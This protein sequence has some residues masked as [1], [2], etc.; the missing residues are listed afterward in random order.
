VKSQFFLG[1]LSGQHFEFSPVLYGPNLSSQPYLHG[2][3]FSF[4][5]TAN[6][7]FGMGFTAQ[8]GGP[9]NPFTWH[10]FLRTFYS[11]KVGVGNNPGKRLSEFDFTY[12]V[13]KLRNWAQIYADLM[14]ID[15]YSPLLSHRPA[16]NPG[17]YISHFPKVPKLDLRAEGVTTDLNVPQHFGPGAFYWDDRYHSGYTDN[18]NL[19]GSWIGR[20][21]RGE[22]AWMTY[23]FSSRSDI[24]LGYRHNNVDRAFLSGGTLQDLSLRTDVMLGSYFQL[25][26]FVQQEHWHFPVLAP[27]GK[28]DNSASVQLTF[29]PRS[30]A[31]SSR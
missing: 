4:H 24:Q 18:G 27:T 17:I 25:S 2:T 7:E 28:S 6:L 20:R 21:G 15:E 14:V 10:N 26:A 23:R 22:Q 16:I 12:R 8:F 29:W 31:T 3:K 5:P 30:M 11:H 19:I 1:Q 9:G 13:P